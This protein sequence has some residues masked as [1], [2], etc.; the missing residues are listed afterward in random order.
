MKMK[1]ESSTGKFVRIVEDRGS[2][3]GP[4]R[5]VIVQPKKKPTSTSLS[6]I[7]RAVREVHAASK[8]K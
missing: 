4:T 5:V 3:H 7:R 6:E 8:G 1:R 2:G